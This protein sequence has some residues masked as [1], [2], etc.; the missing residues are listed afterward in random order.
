MS[1]IVLNEFDAN[2][3]LSKAGISMAK[4][5]LCKSKEEVL[6]AIK[7][8]NFP[9]VLKILSSDIMHKT[10][11]G[12]VVVGIE[13][14]ED[15]LEAY[16][17]VINNAKKYNSNANIQGVIVQQ[18]LS[19]GLEV[20]FGV[21]KDEQFGHTVIFGMG[22]IYV[23]IYE[24]VALRILPIDEDQAVEMINETKISKILKGAR[25]QNYNFSEVID[26][27]LKLSKYVENNPK[28]EEIDINPYILYDDGSKGG[29]VDSL[30]T[31]TE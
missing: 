25:G 12:C 23:E 26:V 14:N 19:K 8:V 28:V 1:K 10:E 7:E 13:N 20:I 31:M 29:G 24:D 5:I 2:K 27:L 11:A 16:D 9:V 18:M 4:T 6:K 17:R 30:I 22:G 15:L 3:D 21:K